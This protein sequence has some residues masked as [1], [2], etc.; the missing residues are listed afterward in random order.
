MDLCKSKVLVFYLLP[1]QVVSPLDV[2]GLGV[3]GCILCKVDG[4]L[5]IVVESEFILSNPQLYDEVLHS[6][7]FLAG[8]YIRHILRFQC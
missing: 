3:V 5:N 2:L 1:E 8:F 4:A 7:Y 6:Y